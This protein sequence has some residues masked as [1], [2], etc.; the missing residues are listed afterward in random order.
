MY[1]SSVIQIIQNK[2][3]YT[4]EELSEKLTDCGYP[5]NARTLRRWSKNGFTGNIQNLAE[6]FNKMNIFN[7]IGDKNGFAR[8]GEMTFRKKQQPL[9]KES[10]EEVIFFDVDLLLPTIIKASTIEETSIVEETK[11]III[12]LQN[13]I[14]TSLCLHEIHRFDEKQSITIIFVLLFDP[15]APISEQPSDKINELIINVIKNFS[16]IIGKEKFL[17]NIKTKQKVTQFTDTLRMEIRI[18]EVKDIDLIVSSI[19]AALSEY[20]GITQ[21]EDTYNILKQLIK[22]KCSNNNDVIVSIDRMEQKPRSNARKM[23]LKEQVEENKLYE[24]TDIVETAKKLMDKIEQAI[25]KDLLAVAA[26][27]CSGSGS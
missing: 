3:G 26:V 25:I 16:D 8:F 23:E 10:L 1:T 12:E 20:R 4:Q 21:V 5:V 7:I 24:I 27:S 22:K 18:Y 6:A 2:L 13:I 9:N 11:K 17:T 19:V 14:N 15:N